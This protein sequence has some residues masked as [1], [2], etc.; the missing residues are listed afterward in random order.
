MIRELICWL[1]RESK[2]AVGTKSG[3]LRRVR[4]KSHSNMNSSKLE[5]LKKNVLYLAL[6]LEVREC[7][8]IS[9]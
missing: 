2:K 7:S 9:L 3:G 5:P 4:E 6:A 1:T 8:R